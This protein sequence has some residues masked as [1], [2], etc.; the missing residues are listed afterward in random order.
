MCLMRS[1]RPIVPPLI[2]FVIVT[3]S[4]LSA[5]WF[6]LWVCQ[7]QPAVCELPLVP[8]E[9]LVPDVP[10]VPEVPV[11]PAAPLVP[12]EPAVPLVPLVPLLPAELEDPIKHESIKKYIAI[13]PEI[14]DHIIDNFFGNLIPS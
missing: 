9:P 13:R 11:E 7:N 12:T 3:K 8:T 14:K 6:R 4:R 10:E 5:Y 2:R 1:S